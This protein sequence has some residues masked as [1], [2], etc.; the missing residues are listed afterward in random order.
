MNAV[1]MA[2]PMSAVTEV[3]GVTPKFMLTVL[4]EPKPDPDNVIVWPTAPW[5]L[6]SVIEA[7]GRFPP[8]VGVLDDPCVTVNVA[9]AVTPVDVV[10]VTV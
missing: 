2:P 3:T 10:A 5:F 8:G 9:D 6:L 7:V 1:L 4:L